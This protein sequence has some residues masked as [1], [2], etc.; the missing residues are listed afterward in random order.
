MQFN[1]MQIDLVLG[2]LAL[3]ASSVVSESGRRRSYHQQ[4][5]DQRP[6]ILF[7]SKIGKSGKNYVKRTEE[8]QASSSSENVNGFGT[9]GLTDAT[10]L[11]GK[12]FQYKLPENVYRGENTHYSVRTQ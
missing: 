9:W 5:D 11:A 10:A 12:L 3:A 2:I 7:D 1:G 4:R 6:R 8:S